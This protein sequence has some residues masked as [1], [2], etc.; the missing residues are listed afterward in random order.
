MEKT[1]RGKSN[2]DIIRSYLTGERPFVQIGYTPK[3]IKRKDGDEWTDACGKRWKMVNGAKVSVNSQAE[4]IREMT[5]QKCTCGQD[6]RY[7][8]RLDA[9][10]FLKT[11]KCFD[12]IIKEETELRILGVYHHYENYKMLSNYLGY[13]EDM[14]QKIEESIHH[15]ETESDTL[16]VLCNSEGFL[17]KFKGMN[18]ADLLKA[19]RED[20]IEITKAI[21]KVTKDK[22]KAKRIFDTELARVKKANTPKT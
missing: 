20:L 22:K 1:Y 4:M 6:I 13:L 7:G 17:E 8:N 21:T 11:G 5:R 9:K 10:F 2:L 18:T 12:C 3:E 19:A 16:N 14:K 15:F